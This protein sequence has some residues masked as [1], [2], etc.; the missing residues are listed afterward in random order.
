MQVSSVKAFPG[1]ADDQCVNLQE[2]I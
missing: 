1:G 2:S